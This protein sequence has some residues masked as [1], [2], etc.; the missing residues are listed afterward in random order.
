M[1]QMN[2]Q[3]AIWKYFQNEAPESFLGSLSRLR[4]LLKSIIAPQ[5]VLNIGVGAGILERLALDKGLDIYTMDPDTAAIE[6]MKQRLRMG[7]KARVGYGEKMPFPNAM[8]D[9]VVASE[10]LEHLSDDSIA[11]TL[12]EIHR[13]LKPGGI[14]K[15]TVPARENLSDQIV[16]CP[17]C[18]MHFHRWGH[19]QSFTSQRMR[20]VLGKVFQLK[21]VEERLFITYSVLN[22]SGCL[23]GTLKL[24]MFK[25]G[26]N[27]SNQNVYFEVCKRS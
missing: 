24:I 5:I 15:G 8:F 16:I 2:S 19:Q 23:I 7:D 26:R 11:A 22:F 14:F 4:F 20:E 6:K 10:V 18:S 17:G 9:V 27:G 25:L 21:R 13:I 12:Q 3:D 1:S